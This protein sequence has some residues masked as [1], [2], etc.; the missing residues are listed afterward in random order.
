ME[1]A[2]RVS[3]EPP[4]KSPRVGVIL[5][6]TPPSELIITDYDWS[7]LN[8]SCNCKRKFFCNHIMGLHLK[9]KHQ[10]LPGAMY[11]G[12][13]VDNALDHGYQLWSLNTELRQKHFDECFFNAVYTPE[14][15]NTIP[16]LTVRKQFRE[17]WGVIKNMGYT[18]ELGHGILDEYMS[19]Y[20]PE[21][22][23]IIDSD[24]KG[25]IPLFD[26]FNLR[27]KADLLY[28]K[29]NKFYIMET[30]TTSQISE[31]W[32]AGKVREYQTDGY[33]MGAEIFFGQDIHAVTFNA[34][35]TKAAKVAK[36]AEKYVRRDI[37]KPSARRKR[38]HRWLKNAIYTVVD[39]QDEMLGPYNNTDFKT[40][41]EAAYELYK[42]GD[43][44]WLL[45]TESPHFCTA[46]FKK[47][48][49]YELCEMDFHPAVLQNYQR[50]EW[51]PYMG[52]EKF[53]GK[54]IDD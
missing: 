49:Y 20:W 11:F 3:P 41:Q 38:Y 54:D 26:Q 16:Y 17:D 27:F 8:L 13:C 19:V 40:I 22:F 37:L 1:T 43:K 24:V 23:D 12:W 21:Q 48:E 30:K 51:Q 33:H 42:A 34:I 36:I 9:P 31:I 7:M 10:G 52:H 47:C 25:V 50:S 46:F 6:P 2:R 4:E 29:K 39:L 32:W 44:P 53:K 28:H 15:F 5:E 18:L 14:R 45:W 35:A